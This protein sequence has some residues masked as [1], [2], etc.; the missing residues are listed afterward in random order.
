MGHHHAHHALGVGHR[1]HVQEE[2]QVAARPGRRR[3]VAVEAVVRVVGRDVVAPVLEAEGRIGDDPVVGEQPPRAVHQ[4]RLGDDVAGLQACGPQAVEEQVELADGQGAQVALLAVE[5]QVA[6]VSPVLPHVLGGV[7]EHPAGAGRG[8]A[9]AHALLRLQQLH[10]E[11]H[12]R[13]RRVELAALLPG[14]V[15]E[16]VDEVLVGVAQDVAPAGRVLPEVLV[17]QV[18]AAEVGEQAADDALPVGGAAQLL[19]VVPVGARQDAVQPGCVGLLD[20]VAGDVERLAQVHR[21]PNQRR[22][23]HRLR[24]EELVLVAVGERDL[25]ATPEAD[26][27]LHLLVEAVREALEEENGEDV[28]LVV[29]RVD[30]PAQDVRGLPQFRL[31]F[32]P[33]QRHGGLLSPI[34][35]SVRPIWWTSASRSVSRRSRAASTAELY[36]ASEAS[37][38]RAAVS[39]HAGTE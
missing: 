15:G 14:V 28:V 39:S 13:A 33:S 5:R 38:S 35:G 20:G 3:A 10:D 30:L 21:R 11:A 29:G 36:A 4:A 1:Q 32:D 22:P 8:V 23:A 19:L 9:D 27:V 24:D 7:D 12:H 34:G 18:K 37:T 25:A 6:E 31:E 17:A 16:L 2:G 26:R